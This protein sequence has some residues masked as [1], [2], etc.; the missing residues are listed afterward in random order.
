MIWHFVVI[1]KRNEKQFFFSRFFWLN[2]ERKS[3][4]NKNRIYRLIQNKS[5]H[6][7]PRNFWPPKQRMMIINLFSRFYNRLEDN[8]NNNKPN[9]NTTQHN[10]NHI[11]VMMM[12][13]IDVDKDIKKDAW[14]QH[15]FWSDVTCETWLLSLL[16][17]VFAINVCL[18]S[19]AF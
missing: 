4:H 9:E 2:F 1:E 5:R 13:I 6:A 7:R 3:S 8:I 10:N 12:I 16:F 19:R 17:W 11:I 15:A 14:K 18:H